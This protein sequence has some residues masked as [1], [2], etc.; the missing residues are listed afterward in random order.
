MKDWNLANQIHIYP[1]PANEQLTISTKE[2]V[3]GKIILSDQLGKTI[4]EFY[5]S[6]ANS[7]NIDISNYE[8]GIYFIHLPESRIT[9]RFIKSK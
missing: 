3:L 8:N 5:L 9:F 4:K 1:N 7:I 6:G 2:D